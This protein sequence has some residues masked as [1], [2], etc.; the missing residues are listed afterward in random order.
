LDFLNRHKRAILI[1]L[2]AL[3]VAALFF[4]IATVTVQDDEGD[5]RHSL[6]V[7]GSQELTEFREERGLVEM[8]L[9]DFDDIYDRVDPDD[10]EMRAY[11]R[12]YVRQYTTLYGIGQIKAYATLFFVAA[13]G[14][15]VL[16]CMIAY[17][18]P[19]SIIALLMLFAAPVLLTMG[20]IFVHNAAALINADFEAVKSFCYLDESVRGLTIDTS[21][22]FYL[23]AALAA[24]VAVFNAVFRRP[25]ESNNESEKLARAI[26]GCCAV[27]SVAAV[28]FITFFLLNT[29]IPTIFRDIGVFDFIFGTEWRPTGDNPAFGIWYLILTSVYGMAGAVL[30]GV[31][32]GILTAICISQILP[33][34]VKGFVS[35]AVDLLAGIPSVVYGVIGYY[36]VVPLIY[37]LFK[38]V[39]DPPLA[40][41][42]SLLAAI[43]VLAVM[44][45][46]TIVSIT[47]ASLN[48]VP[49]TYMEASLALGLTKEASVFKIVLPAAK[50][51][52]LTGVLL[53]LGRAIGEAMAIIMVAGN[54]VAFPGLFRYVRFLTTGVVAEMSYAADREAGSLHKDALFSIGLVL[55]VFILLINLLFKYIIKRIGR[56][57]E[58]V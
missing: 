40:N 50:S 13:V 33:Q 45:L 56:K 22:F 21:L 41:G 9:D 46:P 29:G 37:D 14:L 53:G 44:V 52:V 6:S 55:F 30:I 28:G 17:V 26:L 51:G 39:T 7:T 38:N 5:T 34:R 10:D 36:I 8:S 43:I 18:K 31:P 42:Y 54:E 23:A 4:P 47:V 1:V 58:S 16:S 12:E 11:V 27:I 49:Q 57:Y 19:R 20:H 25:G 35:V 32:F 24:V 3:A 48:A 2:C 15:L